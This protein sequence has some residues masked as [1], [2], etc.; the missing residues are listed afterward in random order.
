MFQ[1]LILVGNLG[2]DP[3]MRYTPSGQAICQFP[4]ATNRTYTASNGEKVKETVWF[5][6]NAWGKTGEACNEY[7][8]KGGRVLIEGRLNADKATGGPRLWE[9][10]EGRPAA[11][12]EVTATTV[13]FLTSKDEGRSGDSFDDATVTDAEGDQRVGGLADE[14]IPF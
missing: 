5:R 14:D 8:K 3:E 4:V 6:I 1:T 9:T 12:F 11:S 13:R 10:K 7:L 2:K